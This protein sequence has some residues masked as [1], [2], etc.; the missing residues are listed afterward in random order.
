MK[1][2]EFPVRGLHTKPF[3]G[4]IFGSGGESKVGGV[5]THLA[6]LHYLKDGVLHLIL[7]R[8]QSPVEIVGRGATLRTMGF[9]DNNGKLLIR[10]IFNTINNEGEFL[11]GGYDDFLA[12]LQGLLQFLRAHGWCNDI[13]DL[14]KLLDVVAQLLI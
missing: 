11:Y 8:A 3:Q 13:L 12:A 9:V 1:R 2:L 10:K 7:I 14:G 4:G 5:I 6:F